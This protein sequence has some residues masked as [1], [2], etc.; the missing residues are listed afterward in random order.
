[1]IPSLQEVHALVPYE[2][3]QPMFLR[4]PPRPASL[5]VE[6]QR[7]RLSDAFERV[8]ENGFRELQNSQ[9]GLALRS[10]PVA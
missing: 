1:M 10:N 2:V 8:P 6:L 9:S 3:D 4:H 5:E 7:F